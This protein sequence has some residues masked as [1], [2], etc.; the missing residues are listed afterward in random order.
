MKYEKWLRAVVSGL[1]VSL[2][3][4]EPA[5]AEVLKIAYVDADKILLEAPQGKQALRKLEEE[6]D[7]RDK[8]LK[9]MASKL[10]KMEDE[11]NANLSVL[12]SADQRRL[13]MT[14][15]QLRRR[16]KQSQQELREDYNWRRNEELTKLQKLVGEAIEEVA[17]EGGYNLIIDDKIYVSPRLDITKK[18]LEKLAGELRSSDNAADK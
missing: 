17:K 11:F 8:E 9:E 2:I 7:P 4:I 1:L 10:K 3:S 13:K 18:V 6:F 14:I 5:S 16:L 15:I 12:S